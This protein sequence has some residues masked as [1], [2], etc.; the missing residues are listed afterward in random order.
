MNLFLFQSH[1]YCKAVSLP[2]GK[3]T[4]SHAAILGSSAALF[5]LQDYMKNISVKYKKA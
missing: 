5:M 2:I 1:L 4:E 3:Y